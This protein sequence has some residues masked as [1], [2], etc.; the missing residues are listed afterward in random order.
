VGTEADKN[1]A[2]GWLGKLREDQQ[3]AK[4]DMA[5]IISQTLPKNVESFD[6]IDRV[7]VAHPRCAIPV[8]IAP[9]HALIELATTRNAQV[10]QQSKM[11][12]I[13][14]YLTGPRF[15]QRLEGIVEKFGELKDD[16]EKE[17]KFMIRSWVTALC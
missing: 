10:G 15:R 16:L 8:S 3:N 4:A 2:D 9:R 5:L 7:W 13:Y 17:R 11:E 6:L 14:N 1:W 12:Q